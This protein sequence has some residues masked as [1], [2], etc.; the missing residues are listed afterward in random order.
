MANATA[1]Q[2]WCPLNSPRPRSRDC[3]LSSIQRWRPESQETHRVLGNRRAAV[4]RWISG[5]QVEDALTRELT[6]RLIDL[7]SIVAAIR[8]SR[9]LPLPTAEMD[10]LLTQAINARGTPE[11]IR[12]WADRLA[13]DV[14]DL[15]D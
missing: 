2:S 13:A 14:G 3:A 8:E 10:Q 6:Q 5:V 4:T 15:T 12:E 9:P 7:R 11:N 1:M